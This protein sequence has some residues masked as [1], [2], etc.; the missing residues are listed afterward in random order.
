M[1]KPR[2]QWNWN[3]YHRWIQEGR[4]RGEGK[5]YVPWLT[6]HDL[7]SR[8]ISS[9]VPGM[10]TGRMHQLLSGLETAMFYILDA[11]DLAKD[12]R[13]QFPLLPL[14]KTLRIADEMG[15]RHPRER[16]PACACGTEAPRLDK[17]KIV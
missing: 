15:I 9:R 3:T 14:E 6:I 13:E 1:G 7:A 12:I 17:S 4:G 2:A 16:V 8:G 10:T 5:D 11:S